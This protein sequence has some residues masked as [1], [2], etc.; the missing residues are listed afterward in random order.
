MQEK[1]VKGASSDA[2]LQVLAQLNKFLPQKKQI[3]APPK[4]KENL[5][6]EKRIRYAKEFFVTER[7]EVIKMGAIISPN[8]HIRGKLLLAK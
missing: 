7:G 2:Q 8:P 5:K 3:T 4:E 6:D 1:L